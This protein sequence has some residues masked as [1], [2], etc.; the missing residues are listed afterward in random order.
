M[1]LMCSYLQELILKYDWRPLSYLLNVE[2]NYCQT[3]SLQQ[4]N[5]SNQV[6]V[7]INLY[8]FNRPP[9]E[10]G[11]IEI[12]VYILLNFFKLQFYCKFI[13]LHVR[14]HRHNFILHFVSIDHLASGDW[15]FRSYI[16]AR[17]YVS[18]FEVHGLQTYFPS[19]SVI[20]IWT[21]GMLP[22]QTSLTYKKTFMLSLFCQL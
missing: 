12:H 2:F 8:S 5:I 13:Y 6:S 17:S 14:I 7:N 21:L 3:R 16:Y 20:C 18:S 22:R 9:V 15:V 1:F 10:R 4:I 11:E 19:N